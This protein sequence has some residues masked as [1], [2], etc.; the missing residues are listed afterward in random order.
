AQGGPR[1]P[2]AAASRPHEPGGRGAPRRP[3]TRLLDA[4]WD[5]LLPV[6]QTL[7]ESSEMGSSSTYRAACSRAFL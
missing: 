2:Q 7:S 4:A 3:G 1:G 6:G 5:R